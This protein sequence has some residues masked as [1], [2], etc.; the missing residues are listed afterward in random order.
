MVAYLTL[1]D[2]GGVGRLSG[3]S[4]RLC[5]AKEV[6]NLPAATTAALLAS[7]PRVQAKLDRF[8]D[9]SQEA[10]HAS[11]SPRNNSIFTPT[12]NADPTFRRPDFA[13]RLPPAQAWRPCRRLPWRQSS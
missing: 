13:T 2:Y 7:C 4:R 12:P 3:L 9:S 11:N 1:T 5:G 10:S 6:S 8:I